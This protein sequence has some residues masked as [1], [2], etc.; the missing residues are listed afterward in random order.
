M[1]TSLKT[2]VFMGSARSI[3]A[4]W[5]GDKR[6]GDRVLN[7][8]KATLKDRKGTLGDE[9]ISHDVTIVDPVDVFKPDGALGS[10]SAGELSTTTFMMKADDLPEKTKALME[11]IRSADCYLIVSPE[12]NHTV[13]P[14]LAS[15]M[16]HFGGSLYKCKPSGIITYS[17]G[18]FAGMRAAMSIQVMCHELGCL[19]VSKL[20]GIPAV[21]DLFNEDGTPKDPEARMLKQL[22]ELL[23]QLEWMAM[24]MKSQREKTGAF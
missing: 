21:S 7:W 20:V 9:T 18:P 8:V 15:V 1:T 17:P 6:L 10:I 12:Y 16:G 24:A 19:P 3:P 4:F 5:G 23:D 13:P 2:V 14:A 11:T 22:P